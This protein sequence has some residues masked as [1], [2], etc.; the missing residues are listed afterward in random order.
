[1]IDEMSSQIEVNS[2]HSKLKNKQ[3]TKTFKSTLRV[4]N[5]CFRFDFFFVFESFNVEQL[6]KWDRYFLNTSPSSSPP[7]NVVH[8]VER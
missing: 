5:K 2:T 3:E 8:C 1:M 4:K 7:N 6:Q